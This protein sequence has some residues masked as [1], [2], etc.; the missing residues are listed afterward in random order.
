MSASVSLLST[1]ACGLATPPGVVFQQ[2]RTTPKD[3][4]QD[5]PDT[6]GAVRGPDVM[7]RLTDQCYRRPRS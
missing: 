6:R 1:S 2:L 4:A 7:L 5:H 3:W